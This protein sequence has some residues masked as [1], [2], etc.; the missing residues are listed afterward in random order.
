MKAWNK[1][2]ALSKTLLIWKAQ[3]ACDNTYTKKKQTLQV[4]K[5]SEMMSKLA[6]MSGLLH[7]WD[8]MGFL[9]CLGFSDLIY[10]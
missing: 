5:G 1:V 7:V 9:S 6:W 10:H 2:L 8:V 4:G 3:D